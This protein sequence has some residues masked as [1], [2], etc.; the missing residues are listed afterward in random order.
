MK[1][2]ILESWFLDMLRLSSRSLR[3]S[4]WARDRFSVSSS[5]VT[6]EWEAYSKSVVER[7]GINLSAPLAHFLL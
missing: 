1:D 7:L 3:R 2:K 6:S 4:C 5:E